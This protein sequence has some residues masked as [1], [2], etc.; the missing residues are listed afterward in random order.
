MIF[1]LYILQRPSGEISGALAPSGEVLDLLDD[2]ADSGD[3]FRNY[4]VKIDILPYLHYD[5]EYEKSKDFR[6]KALF[7]NR[8]G[9][10]S[11][12]APE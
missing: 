10:C 12:G 11:P 8:L 3:F 6:L 4:Y 5:L 9:N 1:I 7:F 2:G